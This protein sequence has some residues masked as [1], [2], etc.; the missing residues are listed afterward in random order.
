MKCNKCGY[1]WSNS[2]DSAH[3]CGPLNPMQMSKPPKSWYIV[4]E[5]NSSDPFD[6]QSIELF[7]S[8]NLADAHTFAYN[9]WLKSNKKKAFT[10]IQPYDGSCRGG[11]G[12]KEVPREPEKPSIFDVIGLL[13]TTIA[14]KEILLET[15]IR[16][17]NMSNDRAQKRVASESVHMLTINIDELKRILIDIKNC[18]EAQ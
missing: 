10:I 8:D 11:Y 15:Y 13:E 9:K 17:L 1:D 16:L 7:Q 4:Y 18:K 14:G 2:G 3:V 5:C 6:H 12:L